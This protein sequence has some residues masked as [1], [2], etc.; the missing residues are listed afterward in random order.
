MTAAERMRRYRAKRRNPEV[1]AKPSRKGVARNLGLSE[2]HLYTIIQYERYKAFDW[3]GDILDGKHG[4]CG[5]SFIADVCRHTDAEGQRIIHD[6]IKRKGAA[7]GRRLWR[8]VKRYIQEEV[9]EL[10]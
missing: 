1:P 10:S 7:A 2:R 9:D 5:I 4:R 3:D 8:L 6:R